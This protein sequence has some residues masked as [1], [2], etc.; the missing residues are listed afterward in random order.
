MWS[1]ERPAWCGVDLAVR[2]RYKQA[3]EESG[4]AKRFSS[5]AKAKPCN[6]RD[7]PPIFKSSGDLIN[8]MVVIFQ[9]C[10][11]H[12]SFSRAERSISET[13]ICAIVYSLLQPAD[14]PRHRT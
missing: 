5:R 14:M 11:Y 4:N 7:T 2:H 3:R 9:R 8:H 13:Y 12:A 10:R 1:W 6:A